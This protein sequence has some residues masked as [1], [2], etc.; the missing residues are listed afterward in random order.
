MPRRALWWATGMAGGLQVQEKHQFMTLQE[1]MRRRARTTD[2]SRFEDRGI[3]R[4]FKT[5]QG[6]ELVVVDDKTLIDSTEEEWQQAF[7][8]VLLKLD[9]VSDAKYSL[10]YRHSRSVRLPSFA[11]WR[12]CYLALGRQITKHAC[13][14]YV[15]SPSF[16]CR[17]RIVFL[18]NIVSEKGLQKIHKV[19]DLKA[20][21][22]DED[23]EQLQTTMPRPQVPEARGA[24]TRLFLDIVLEGILYKQSKDKN[25]IGVKTWKKRWVA[26]GREALYLYNTSSRPDA[27]QEPKSII[28]L[29]GVSLVPCHSSSKRPYTFALQLPARSADSESTEVINFAGQSDNDVQRWITAISSQASSTKVFGCS[30]EVHLRS[31]NS[32]LELPVVAKRCIAAI[33]QRGLKIEGILRVAGSALRIQR[34]R[35]LFDVVGDYDVEEEADIHTVASL[36]KLY[37]RELPEPVVPFEFYQDLVQL[38]DTKTEAKVPESKLEKL[39][40]I[41][42]L[43]P[44]CNKRLLTALLE[45]AVE[46]IDNV[47]VNK[48][49]AQGMATVLGPSLLRPNRPPED[50]ASVQMLSDSIAANRVTL[51]LVQNFEFFRPYLSTITIDS[52]SPETETYEEFKERVCRQLNLG[53]LDKPKPRSAKDGGLSLSVLSEEVEK[54]Q[55]ILQNDKDDPE[56]WENLASAQTKA[57]EYQDAV[58]SYK[59]AIELHAKQGTSNA[60]NYIKM[61]LIYESLGEADQ[62]KEIYRQCGSLPGG[63]IASYMLQD[64]MKRMQLLED[65]EA[66]NKAASMTSSAS[67]AWT[68]IGTYVE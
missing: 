63:L 10:L 24:S 42:C 61:G 26:V 64:L 53:A 6:E 48:M 33:K 41:V 9:D 11:W 17:E 13:K 37:L 19:E 22:Q 15:E 7:H 2:L 58:S 38:I 68:D 59:K 43:L 29:E 20:L 49:S 62:A 56:N 4:R 51:V 25:L 46:I 66:G 16:A 55:K 14:V 52:N 39:G 50:S 1:E 23:Y 54:L 21:V 44:D 8:F 65:D 36:L 12:R 5:R 60:Q 47:D 3:I 31:T 67:R 35:L 30:L 28:L 18:S 27:D 45:L 32:L 57:C 40:R 34:L